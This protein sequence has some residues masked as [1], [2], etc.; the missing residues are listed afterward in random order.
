MTKRISKSTWF[1]RTFEQFLH[2]SC[3]EKK[4][5]IQTQEKSTKEHNHLSVVFNAN[6]IKEKLL[7]KY[8]K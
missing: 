4:T 5:L 8:T 6:C 1:Y 2:T 7:P 3:P